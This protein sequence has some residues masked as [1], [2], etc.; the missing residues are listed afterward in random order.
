[1]QRINKLIYG[2]FKLFFHLL[3]HQMAWS[4]NAVAWIVSVG[5]W[6]DWVLSVLPYLDRSPILELGHGPG[7]LMNKLHDS[8]VPVVGLDGS[9][10]MGQIARR[11]IEKKSRTPLLVNG[12][13]QFLPFPN[14]SFSSVV[15]TFPSE[16]IANPSTLQEIARVLVDDGEFLCLPAAWITG[17]GPFHR[18]AATL[19]KITHQAPERNA[20]LEQRAQAL[21]DLYGFSTSIIYHELPDSVVMIIK[22][23]KKT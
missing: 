18:A 14:G 21:L 19:F 23:R 5:Q 20:N 2:F 7:H 17:K 16:Y 4:Y 3:Y 10:Q 15:A 12:Y 11:L 6:K 1:M 22:S 8:G 9:R 13:A